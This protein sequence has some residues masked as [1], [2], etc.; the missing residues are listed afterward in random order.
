M[1]F[2]EWYKNYN[3]YL[4]ELYL[5]FQEACDKNNVD[6]YNSIDYQSFCEYIWDNSSGY[7]SPS[8]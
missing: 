1:E 5:V 2:R 4:K 6:W 8:L 3:K 7:I